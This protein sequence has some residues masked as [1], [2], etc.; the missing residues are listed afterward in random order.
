MPTETAADCEGTRRFR[1]EE[2]FVISS[3][4]PDCSSVPSFFLVGNVDGGD[5]ISDLLTA[6]F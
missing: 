1:V 6:I 5:R 4:L 3:K 2:G